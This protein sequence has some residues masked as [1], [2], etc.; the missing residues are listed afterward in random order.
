[1]SVKAILGQ[2]RRGLAKLGD[3][4]GGGADVEAWRR[5]RATAQELLRRMEAQRGVLLAD[6][7]G[8]GKTWVA[9]LAALAVAGN[10][11]RALV[12]A[13]NADL[14]NKW[15]AELDRVRELI[16]ADGRV[17]IRVQ[18]HRR[19]LW[20]VERIRKGSVVV[21]TH[22]HLTDRMVDGQV[23][24][25]PN[26][27]ADLLIVDEA[28]RSKS[29]HSKFRRKLY[30]GQQRFEKYL[31]LTATPFSISL[32]ELGS[33][34]DLIAGG[35]CDERDRA[36]KDFVR[37][38]E[39]TGMRGSGLTFKQAEAIWRNALEKLRPWVIR[40]TIAS[41]SREERKAFGRSDTRIAAVAGADSEV[42]AL[43]VRAD[44]LFSL[45]GSPAGIIAGDPRFHVGWSYLR[46]LLG[47]T[48]SQLDGI[49][50]KRRA[51]TDFIAG[52]ELA[53]HHARELK[54]ALTGAVH[55][56]IAA[57]ASAVADRVVE[58]GEKVV[59]FCHYLATAEELTHALLR[60]PRLAARQ[61]RLESVAE[62][63]SVEWRSVWGRIVQK[64][65]PELRDAV[66]EWVCSRAFRGQV[67]S[68]LGEAPLRDLGKALRS[69]RVRGLDHVWRAPS[70]RRAVLE[71]AHFNHR[72]VSDS[73]VEAVVPPI[74]NACEWESV[75]K[76]DSKRSVDELA[77]FN[78]PFGPDV[79]VATDRHSEGVDLHKGC[80]LLMHY[81]L[82]PSPV[83]VKQREGRVRR[84][85]GW[86]QR[87]RKPVEYEYP[88][89]AGTRD[90]MLVNIVTARLRYFDLLL[91][92]VRSVK[93]VDVE[94]ADDRD[95]LERLLNWISKESMTALLP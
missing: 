26:L 40:H 13:P 27:S 48:D 84:V 9:A 53:A 57:V 70:I 95:Q 22:R 24:S 59:V 58:E 75:A 81:E 92:G 88:Y 66:L 78:S 14:Q 67:M 56:K 20:S 74:F 69:R 90:E 38:A 50:E 6:D 34:L 15:E 52:S 42:Q 54:Q 25:P 47:D 44:R 5:Q 4:V 64:L 16:G 31:F 45:P 86:A 79:L 7:T 10:G 91:G 41:L 61:R 1:M 93:D 8:L 23:Q 62:Q 85:G 2:G 37:L 68:W 29:D 11:G 36:L 65:D 94:T 60:E 72:D 17:R 71:L 30:Q 76:A 28:H 87:I 83:R 33:M 46:S 82:D 63:P 49:G 51:V 80:R 32:K 43:L 55:P 12:L 39:W 77:L 18:G 21:A 3:V 73:A 19:G 89:F 35:A